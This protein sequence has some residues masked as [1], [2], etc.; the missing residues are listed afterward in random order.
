M[1]IMFLPSAFVASMRQEL[2]G[3]PSTNTVQEPQTPTP[4]PST[5]PL[6]ERSSRKHSNRVSF[7]LTVS[8]CCVPLIVVEMV[9]GNLTPLFAGIEPSDNLVRLYRQISYANP[10]ERIGNG[11]ADGRRHRWQRRFTHTFGAKGALG[12]GR[13]DYDGLKVQRMI[14]HGR[15]HVL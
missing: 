7:D 3:R 8:S 5:E 13:F 15:Q 14:F 2:T 4:Q 10:A 12:V 9:I 1:V 11:I 6:S